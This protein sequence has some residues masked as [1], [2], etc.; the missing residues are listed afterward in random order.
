[1]CVC[2]CPQLVQTDAQEDPELDYE[3]VHEGSHATAR[4]SS[5]SNKSKP[6]K[7]GIEE[8][9]RFY[10]LL[11]QVGTDFSL[12]ETFFPGRNRRQLKL[13]F[14]REEKSHPELVKKALESQSPLGTPA[15][16]LGRCRCRFV[17]NFSCV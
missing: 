3:E 15:H 12:M 13:K 2:T 10:E 6:M 8:T 7:W 9:R 5:F 16:E 17:A 4:Y 14:F 1:M 11:Q